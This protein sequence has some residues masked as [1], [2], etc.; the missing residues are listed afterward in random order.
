MES[1]TEE[2]VL[3]ALEQAEMA[4]RERR[5]DASSE[6]DQVAAV[7][8]QRAAEISA[9]AGRRVEQS[10]DALRRTAETDADEAIAQLEREAA[11]RTPA[12]TKPQAA[13]SHIEEAVAIVVARVLGEP[14][15]TSAAKERA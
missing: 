7:A 6:A 10:L 5:L 1:S 14:A 8:Q 12:S 11:R 2:S 13:E 3:D 9:A 15:P 4:A